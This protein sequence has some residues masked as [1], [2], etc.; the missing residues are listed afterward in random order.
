MLTK[1][2]IAVVILQYIHI[3]NHYV[4][5]LKLIRCESY[6]EIKLEKKK[7]SNT[8]MVRKTNHIAKQWNNQQTLK[9][10][11]TKYVN[12]MG[13]FSYINC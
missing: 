6:F 13:K 9:T 5:P 2:I 11:F 12:N 8:R 10:V 7:L 1:H 4:V 3:S